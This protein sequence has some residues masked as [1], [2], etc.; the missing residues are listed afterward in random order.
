MPETWPTSWRLCQEFWSL[1]VLQSPPK[2]PLSHDG[3]TL[4]IGM[5]KRVA[6]RH[7][8]STNLREGARVQRQSVTDIVEPQTVRQLREDQ[9]QHVTPRFKGARVLLHPSLPGEL[10]NQVIRN[11]VG[12]LAQKRECRSRWLLLLVF[13]FHIRALW[14]GARQ[15]PT[16]F[17]AENPRRLWDGSEILWGPPVR[18]DVS[19]PATW[20]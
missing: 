7:S 4:P 12:N 2:Q 11:E 5:G 20:Y 14:H 17:F 10:R 1:E 15:K 13:L 18:L 3:V 8:S 9:R 19:G 6:L 16:R